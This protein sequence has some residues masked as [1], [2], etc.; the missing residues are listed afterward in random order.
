VRR[1]RAVLGLETV[2][3]AA[4]GDTAGD[5]EMLAIAEERGYRIFR[6][7]PDQP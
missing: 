5:K 6:G 1:I 7:R 3:E 4:Y 2:L